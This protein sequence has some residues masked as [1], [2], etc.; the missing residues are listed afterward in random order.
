MFIDNKNKLENPQPGTILDSGLVENEEGSTKFDFFLVP[1]MTTQGCVMPVH[2]FVTTNESEDLTKEVI[3]NLTYSLC[4][5]Y[6]NW[7]GSIK[8]PAACQL[9]HKIADYHH[10]FD[11]SQQIKKSGPQGAKKEN[12]GYQPK[13][14]NTL[15]YL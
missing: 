2:Y 5:I 15:N 4:Y 14:G 6:P 3:E 13:F 12:L 1:Q 10:G 7:A 9:A 11:V 8:V